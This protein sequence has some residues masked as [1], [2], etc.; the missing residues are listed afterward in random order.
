MVVENEGS[1]NFREIRV[2]PVPLFMKNKTK[3]FL[4]ISLGGKSHGKVLRNT[5]NYQKCEEI[6]VSCKK[7]GFSPP[8]TLRNF[9]RSYK[10]PGLMGA[11]RL[12]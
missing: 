3:G 8:N 4:A 10:E 1:H 2:S 7:H 6:K 12:S 9:T 11:W 5:W